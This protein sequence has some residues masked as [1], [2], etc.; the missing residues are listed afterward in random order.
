VWAAGWVRRGLICDPSTQA[1]ALSVLETEDENGPAVTGRLLR[2]IL[3][4]THAWMG[5]A[6]LA[7][8]HPILP[9][10]ATPNDASCLHGTWESWSRNTIERAAA[11]TGAPVLASR[12][13]VAVRGRAM[14][15]V[16]STSCAVRCRRDVGGP[17]AT[18]K[19][20]RQVDLSGESE[21]VEQKMAD[22]KDC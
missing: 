2:E 12:K 9:L 18:S 21:E 6:A 15:S 13:T 10:S 1:P 7:I 17:A 3:E 19:D 4:N 8:F 11:K 5:R 16:E 14:L 20:N 22:R